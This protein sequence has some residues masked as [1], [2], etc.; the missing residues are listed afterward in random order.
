[1]SIPTYWQEAKIYLSDND[2]VMAGIIAA[3][4]GET[5]R[6]RNDAFIT[7][8]RSITGQ[9][10]SVK[11]AD[12]VWKKLEG[13]IGKIDAKSILE[14]EEELLRASGYSRQKIKYLKHIAENFTNKTISSSKLAKLD[15]EE[16]IK[17]LIKL[18]GRWP[19]DSGNVPDLPH[20]QTRC[21]PH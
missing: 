20:A 16:A 2:Q 1:M 7:L 13:N 11:A 21:L 8:A 10:I 17:E 5:L 12:S 4:E 9:Q 14:C 18:K 15:E 19:L 6:R 3:Y